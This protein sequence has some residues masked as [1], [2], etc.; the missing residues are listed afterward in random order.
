MYLPNYWVHTLRNKRVSH[1]LTIFSEWKSRTSHPVTWQWDRPL[2]N[3]R[4]W[5]HVASPH[6]GRRS[7]SHHLTSYSSLIA[8][9]SI[10][11]SSRCCQMHWGVRLLPPAVSFAS[12]LQPNLLYS[13][14]LNLLGGFLCS[15]FRFHSF[16]FRVRI[17]TIPNIVQS[18]D[19]NRGVFG[20]IEV[21]QVQL[22]R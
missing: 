1:T 6:C 3:H 14:S 5:H 19:K 4:Q 13:Q 17:V 9:I 22:T 10:T 12:F 21:D 20:S 18:S 15:T 11:P 8:D 16:R 7:H 2:L